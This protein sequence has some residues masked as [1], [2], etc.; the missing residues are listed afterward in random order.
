[1]CKWSIDKTN[2]WGKGWGE[3]LMR[4]HPLLNISFRSLFDWCKKI[5][6]PL[7][8]LWN[9]LVLLPLI[10]RFLASIR[11]H[12]GFFTFFTHQWNNSSFSIL[13]LLPVLFVDLVNGTSSASDSFSYLISL[14]QYSHHLHFQL[15][16]LRRSSPLN[17]P[18]AALRLLS[19]LMMY[20]KLQFKLSFHWY[21]YTLRA[22]YDILCTC[23]ALSQP[24]SAKS[25]TE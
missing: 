18:F 11:F 23:L 16:Y 21:L 12:H 19:V 9:I 3:R 14:S 15:L 2:C 20:C 7:A 8:V 25:L 6:N 22:S 5:K 17:L 24:V 13:L 4:K 10:C 1:M